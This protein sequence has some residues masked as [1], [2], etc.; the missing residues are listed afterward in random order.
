MLPL[1][2]KLLH[3]FFFDERAARRWLRG[4]LLAFAGGGLAF[5]DQLSGLVGAPGA[6]K[7]IKIASVVA[8]FIAGA[9]QSSAARTRP[10]AVP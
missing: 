4:G 1:I 3:S 7:G 2:R 9:M 6:V 5:A 10:K 8:G